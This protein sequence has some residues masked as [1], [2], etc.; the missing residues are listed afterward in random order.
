MEWW[1]GAE[2][3]GAACASEGTGA[4]TPRHPSAADAYEPAG[5]AIGDAIG[6]A[7]SAGLAAV[8]ASGDVAGLASSEAADEDAGAGV[9]SD[10]VQAAVA[11]IIESRA[12]NRTFRI[13]SSFAQGSKQAFGTN[14]LQ[15]DITLASTSTQG[16]SGPHGDPSRAMVYLTIRK[17]V[18]ILRDTHF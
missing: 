11:N 12:R 10:L 3:K 8:L 15:N 2:Q 9:S 18:G 13:A 5:E 14:S 6:D 16:Y 7:L 1:N 17:S 4:R